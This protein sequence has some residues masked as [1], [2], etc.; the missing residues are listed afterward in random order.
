[1]NP[2]ETLNVW[3][4]AW[5]GLM[6]RALVDTSVLLVLMLVL[7]LPLRRRVSAHL[8]HGLFCLVLLKLIV[9]IPV[10]WSWWPPAATESARLAAERFSPWARP[11]PPRDAAVVR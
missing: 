3:G 10:S 8:A 11:V 4:G 6:S 5:F 1:M 7:W 2:V 9:P